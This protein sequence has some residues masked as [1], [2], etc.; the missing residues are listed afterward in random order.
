MSKVVIDKNFASKGA[1]KTSKSGFT[2]RIKESSLTKQVR[3][4]HS[5]ASKSPITRKK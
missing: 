2:P 4:S 1:S 3:V 5:F